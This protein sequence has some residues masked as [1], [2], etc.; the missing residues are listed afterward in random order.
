MATELAKTDDT[1]ANLPAPRPQPTDDD[2]AVAWQAARNNVSVNTDDVPPITKA[3]I[4]LSALGPEVAA[5]FLK[6]MNEGA[7]T[8]TAIAISRLDRIPPEML[9]A[10][11]AE[12]LLSI[13]TEEE[14][15][16]GSQTARRLLAEVL[17]DTTIDRIMFD[18]EGGDTRKAWKKLNDI[19]NN[20]LATFVGAEHPQTAAVILSELRADK[21]A[22]VLERLDREFAQQTVLRLSRVPSLD[23]DVA[24]MVETV[25]AR[26]FLSA[27][28]RTKRSRRPADL[29]AGLMNN[30]QSDNREK[31][32]EFLEGEKPSLHSDV[33]KTMFTFNDIRHRVEAREVAIIVKEL[34]EPQLLIA[35]KWGKMQGNASVDFLLENLSKRLTER[36]VED[37]DAMP[38]PT[39]RD[40]EASHQEVV[41]KIQEMAKSGTLQLI[42]DEAPEE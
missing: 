37:L 13:G 38:E 8:R 31:F 5:D 4:V 19:S 32:L 42:E 10:V 40:G 26:D 36:L 29:I 7:L 28:Q 9:D 24:E 25:I 6:N 30:L 16:G 20:A 22:A 12:F 18:V 23:P 33:L 1:Q 34:D 17:D 11:I 21:A 3:A 15:S 41:R 2:M 14:I 35:L 39:Q 27:L